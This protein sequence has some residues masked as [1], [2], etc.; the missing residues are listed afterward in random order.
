MWHRS[1]HSS[2]RST[3][4]HSNIY[5]T[6]TQLLTP[7]ASCFHNTRSFQS[8][9]P[10][11][12]K[13][14]TSL[15]FPTLTPLHNPCR[16]SRNLDV[17]A[18][19]SN[20]RLDFEQAISNIQPVNLDPVPSLI[21]TPGVARWVL[22]LD[23]DAPL[24]HTE[25]A[26]LCR[27]AS[28]RVKTL[29]RR[30]QTSDAIA[31]HDRIARICSRPTTDGA[32][33]A[34]S[35]QLTTSLIHALLW[36]YRRFKAAQI[37]ETALMGTSTSILDGH[38]IRPIFPGMRLSWKTTENIMI[39]LC[40]PPANGGSNPPWKILLQ[41][42]R[43]SEPEWL[44]QV[45][46]LNYRAHRELRDERKEDK[47]FDQLTAQHE[48]FLRDQMGN[49]KLPCDRVGKLPGHTRR[50][51]LFLH[52]LRHSRQRRTGKMFEA[53]VD[54]C[55]LQ[56]EIVV[57]TLLFVLLVRD[58]QARRILQ[59]AQ[60]E[61]GGDGGPP[62]PSLGITQD[63]R[64]RPH[65]RIMAGS[66]SLVTRD[67]PVLGT[68]K[69]SRAV[70]TSSTNRISATKHPRGAWEGRPPDRS[71]EFLPSSHPFVDLEKAHRF[72]LDINIHASEDCHALL[73]TPNPHAAASRYILSS[74][75]HTISNSMP[76]RQGPP[77]QPLRIIAP[78][79]KVDN[80]R[81]RHPPASIALQ[82]LS[83][84][85]GLTEGGALD[86]VPAILIRAI[87]EA[88]EDPRFK[89]VRR[90]VWDRP[91]VKE[92]HAFHK[93]PPEI[94]GDADDAPR[95][96][97]NM[98]E[99]TRRTIAAIIDRLPAPGAPGPAPE[100]D[101]VVTLVRA[102]CVVLR[103]PATAKRVA[104]LAPPEDPDVLAALIQSAL[105]INRVHRVEGIL[106]F[107]RSRYEAHMDDEH[108]PFD[109]RV[110]L[111]VYGLRNWVAEEQSTFDIHIRLRKMLADPAERVKIIPPGESRLLIA[112]MQYLLSIHKPLI[113]G[114]NLDHLL[115]IARI[116]G[117]PLGE[118]A[119]D[120]LSAQG[121]E[122]Y[123]ILVKS[124]VSF[125]PSPVPSSFAERVLGL[126]RMAERRSWELEMRRIYELYRRRSRKDVDAETDGLG[127]VSWTIHPSTYSTMMQ[128]YGLDQERGKQQIQVRDVFPLDPKY[129]RRDNRE[130][131]IA[132]PTQRRALRKAAQQPYHASVAEIS[133]NRSI[134][135]HDDMMRRCSSAPWLE[136]TLVEMW[137]QCE[138][139]DGKVHPS[140]MRR[141]HHQRWSSY[142]HPKRTVLTQANQEY[143]YRAGRL[144]ARD[145][146]N[147]PGTYSVVPG[148]VRRWEDLCTEVPTAIGE[149]ESDQIGRLIK[150]AWRA[151]YR[152]RRVPR[153]RER[154]VPTS[155][156]S[157]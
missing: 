126:A 144:W 125:R 3:L 30:Q 7:T 121:P 44:E 68:S 157:H 147:A 2:A 81:R 104:R 130:L 128:I 4:K 51:I 97:I 132:S 143:F 106:G 12:A 151:G 74:L 69:L 52:V 150:D 33:G 70:D 79:P 111:L 75:I 115:P 145:V 102:A 120:A 122:F 61:S 78:P 19:K 123:D 47:G 63:I 31:F 36:S 42:V 5:P 107:I 35:R 76:H 73:P 11:V 95:A 116:T 49:P 45:R 82:S 152:V 18:P 99:L 71:P 21:S 22:A 24:S 23:D 1:L 14:H 101:V 110:L 56:G 66:L 140:R 41:P 40:P 53:L 28:R 32:P 129:T 55:L 90:V 39:G 93:Y 87:V 64:S 155:Q 37:A 85:M 25:R 154:E 17:L 146:F 6:I 29:V 62:D 8:A 100:K 103:S 15:F 92:L 43:Q 98:D 137:K 16:P 138:I 114:Y 136:Q 54:A 65:P 118:T 133:W 59:Q 108:Q 127:P 96:L 117:K 72:G 10:K 149:G 80:P 141:V 131:G 105:H 148:E 112:I 13:T 156:C 94:S 48:A 88:H 109:P 58:W 91:E 46:G 26:M 50:A 119:L 27:R 67:Q 83:R 60:P 142:R 38:S 34:S 57:G 139:R 77:N 134:A 9:T 84:L 124:L 113:I 20:G 89:S 86:P 135:L 153:P